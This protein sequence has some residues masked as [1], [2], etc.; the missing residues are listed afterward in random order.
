MPGRAARL[1]PESGRPTLLLGLAL[2]VV[3]VTAEAA[4]GFGTQGAVGDLAAGLALFGAG[5]SMRASRPGSWSGPL[6]LLAG[7][8]WFTGDVAGGLVYLHRGPLV[9]LLL[10]YPTGRTR[11]PVTI[12]VIVP[13]YVDGLAPALARADWPTIALSG[14]VV[15]VAAAR[16]FRTPGLERRAAA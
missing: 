9:Q 5:L 11:P 2:L 8:T 10:T 14:A 16:S 1:R 3:G 6:A 13:A 15:A 4:I 12:A 7:L